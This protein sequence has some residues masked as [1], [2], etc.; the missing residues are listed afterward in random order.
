M[1]KFAKMFLLV[2]SLFVAVNASAE[3]LAKTKLYVGTGHSNNGVVTTNS[4]HLNDSTKH[5]GYTIDDGSAIPANKYVEVFVGN[6]VPNNGVVSRDWNHVGGST[7][8]LGYLSINAVPNGRKLYVGTGACNN[9][10]VTVS[11]MHAGCS[12]EFFGYT[13]PPN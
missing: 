1:N 5:I 8:S 2:S 12:T 9:G 13:M 3:L 11:T 7:E 10:V 6:D 4:S